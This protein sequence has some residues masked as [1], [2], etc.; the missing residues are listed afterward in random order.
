MKK[1]G[2]RCPH[3][4]SWSTV[5][6]SVELSPTLRVLYFQCRE[7][8]CGH[9]WKSHLEMVATI[10]PSA[11]PNPL[12]DLPLSPRSEALRLLADGRTDNPNQQPLF[13]DADHDE[14]HLK[15]VPDEDVS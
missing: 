3:C 8:A 11:L 7:L 9:T 10:S 13:G 6:H 4:G 5:R 2:Q 14:Q 1:A 12:I 15:T